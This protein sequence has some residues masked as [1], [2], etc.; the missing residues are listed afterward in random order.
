MYAPLKPANVSVYVKLESVMVPP[1]SDL[2]QL[3][4]G[5]VAAASNCAAVGTGAELSAGTLSLPF[6]G[7]RLPVVVGAVC[8]VDLT[9]TRLPPLLVQSTVA[10]YVVAN[11]PVAFAP[12]TP[13]SSNV[14]QLTDK[15]LESTEQ[16][17]APDWR[18]VP[19]GAFAGLMFV[20]IAAKATEADK[21]KTNIESAVM[22][23]SRRICSVFPPWSP[24]WVICPHELTRRAE[25]A[26]TLRR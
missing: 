10:E 12:P 13:A 11:D 25:R 19:V 2:V 18:C 26:R 3:P 17:I 6:F 1:A 20:E 16:P 7:E 21:A 9:G 24:E 5:Q 4:F 22:V 15:V 23:P 14:L 8:T